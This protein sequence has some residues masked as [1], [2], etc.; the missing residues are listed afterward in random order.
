MLARRELVEPAT[1]FEEVAAELAVAPGT[2]TLIVKSAHDYE[3]D[4][5]QVLAVLENVAGY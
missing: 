3:S 2:L 4:F 1:A 5:D